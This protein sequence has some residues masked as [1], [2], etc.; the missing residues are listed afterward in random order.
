MIH[1]SSF[2]QH[3]RLL[4]LAG[5]VLLAGMVT[6]AFAQVIE[7]EYVNPQVT[8]VPVT[9]NQP[10]TRIEA[11]ALLV[12]ADPILKDRLN[13]FIKHRPPMPL[14]ADIDYAQWQAPYI[15][16]AFEAGLITGNKARLFRPNDLITE[17]EMISIGARAY[18]MNHQQMNEWLSKQ[19]GDWFNSAVTASLQSGLDL[20]FPIRLGQPAKK[21]D[22]M[23]LLSSMSIQN[24]EMLSITNRPNQPIV[25]TTTVRPLQPITQRPS[26]QYVAP[27]SQAPQNNPTPAAQNPTPSSQPAQQ[28]AQP[29][30]QQQPSAK[31]FAISMPS[32]GVKDL[33]IIHPTDPTTQNGLLAPLKNGVG[34]LFSYPG[35]GG[36][37]LVYGHS[38]SY[39]WDVSEYTKIFRQINKLNVGDL[40]YVTYNGKVHTYKVSYEQTVLAS[41]MSAYS[42]G[43]GEELILYTCWPPDD[44]KERYLVHAVPVDAVA[45]N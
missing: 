41:D 13:A 1:Y 25:T 14:F 15:E 10:L 8:S 42:G 40:I 38:S 27:S 39:S 45:Q 24:P 26:Q 44:I 21:G 16:A 4:A 19:S 6:R 5:M 35:K 33:A 18:A 37:I 34:H 2:M 23:T 29:S 12:E 7:I 17:E 31:P 3:K 30:N 43:D 9:N 11:V 32:L 36:T 28:P 20:P 22:F